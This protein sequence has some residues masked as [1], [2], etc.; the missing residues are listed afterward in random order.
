VAQEDERKKISQE[1]RDEIAQNLLGINVRLSLLK[2]AARSKAR[3]LK[4]EIASAQQLVLESAT[5]VR[6]LARELDNHRQ[7]P[8]ELIVTTI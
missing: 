5:L 6:R 4:S 1:L 7:T 8:S 3:G 2:Q